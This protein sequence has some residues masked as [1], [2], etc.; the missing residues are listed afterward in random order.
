MKALGHPYDYGYG[1]IQITLPKE[2]VGIEAKIHME[3]PNAPDIKV[4]HRRGRLQFDYY[5]IDGGG[6]FSKRESQGEAKD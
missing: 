6:H 2:L 1:R 4:R 5:Q 3:F